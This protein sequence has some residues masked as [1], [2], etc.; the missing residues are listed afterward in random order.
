[1][2]EWILSLFGLGA[3]ASGTRR[4]RRRGFS[5]SGTGGSRGSDS[6]SDVA[7]EPT[8]AAGSHS[9]DVVGEASYAR[10]LR[11][12]MRGPDVRWSDE[13]QLKDVL[14][15]LRA[16]PRN[17]YDRDAIRVLVE[18]QTVGYVSRDETSQFHPLLRELRARR[19]PA[20]CKGLIVGKEGRFGVK[21][22]LSLPLRLADAP[23][24]LEGSTRVAVVGEESFQGV[25]STLLDRGSTSF[26]ADLRVRE[27]AVL[28]YIEDRL[29][30]RLTDR[31][32]ERYLPRILEHVG[33]GKLA[34][35]TAVLTQGARKVE[36]FVLLAGE[37]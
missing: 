22:E 27:G 31:M 15:E 35:C 36:A 28:V 3:R 14:V 33:A 6:G 37:A 16:D 32:S 9:H 17:R 13:W 18:D 11:A 20:L 26:P 10:T 24:P 19:L 4:R 7:E 34:S 21:L 12:L 29:V 8:I 2:L 1:M 5:R 30:G 25:L 23:P